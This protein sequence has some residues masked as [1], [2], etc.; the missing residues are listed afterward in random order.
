VPIQP[1]HGR[2]KGVGAGRQFEVIADL[3]G[4]AHATGVSV[5]RPLWKT[6]G[7][8]P[9]MWLMDG[10]KCRLVFR[11]RDFWALSI[12]HR[13]CGKPVENRPKKTANRCLLLE[14]Y[15]FALVQCTTPEVRA[16]RPR[17]GADSRK[18]VVSPMVRERELRIAGAPTPISARTSQAPR[19]LPGVGGS[20]VTEAL[21][22]L[23][24]RIKAL[25]HRQ[26]PGHGE[27]IMDSRRQ[28]E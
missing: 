13:R 28:V 27:E 6:R 9:T 10:P 23:E 18:V 5:N 17:P 14:I 3:R 22:G 26:E 12:F 21:Q 19:R 24:F 20:R 7:F 1:F 25:K 16:Y 8:R 15:R 4:N 11:S 2:V